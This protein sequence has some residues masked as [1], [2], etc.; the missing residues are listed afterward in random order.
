MAEAVRLLLVAPMRIEARALRAGCRTT[1]VVRCGIGPSAAARAAATIPL[2]GCRPLAIAGFCG[3][4]QLGLLP[5]DVV[6]A[7]E[8]RGAEATIFLPCA[9][10]VAHALRSSGSTVHIGPIMSRPGLVYGRQRSVLTA[11]G[12]LVVD[13]ESAW[14]LEVFARIASLPAATAVVRVVLDGT[15]RFALAR[16]AV[17]SV[18]AYR[19]LR[20][21]GRTLESWA[22]SPSS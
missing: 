12:A 20:T 3:G 18:K 21:V 10:A 8:V 19:V 16:S 6:V 17:T 11:D 13:M 1:E 14:L 7:S 4:L 2:T 22:S 15:G 5:G 9:E